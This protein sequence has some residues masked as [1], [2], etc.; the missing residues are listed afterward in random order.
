ML[1][2]EKSER[3]ILEMVS[4]E[5][6]V[7]QDHLLRKIDSAVDFTHIYDFVEDL[8]CADN[9]RPS[10]DPVVLFKM[11]LIQ[12]LYGITSLRRT[13]EEINMN[14]AYR[15]FLGYLLNEPIPHF[16]TISYNFRHRFTEDTIEKVFTWILYEAQKSGYLSPEVVFLDGTHIKANANINKK[17]KK[18]IPAAAR[19]YER[20]L[21][22]EI[23]EDR[24]AHGKKPFDG[25]SGSGAEKQ[26]EI[27]VSTT[28]PESGIF[29]KGEHKR[30]FAYEAHTVCDRHNFILDTVI[31]SGNVHDSVAFD[32]LYERVTERFPEIKIVTMDAGYKTPWICKRVIDDGRL[33]SLPYKRPMTKAGF[34]EWY[35]YVYDE[36]LDIVICPEYKSLQYSTTTRDGYREYKSLSYQCGN[37][38]TRNLCTESQSCQ[39]VVTRHIWADYIER[40][41]DIRHSPE[42]KGSYKLRSQ[43]IERVFADAKEKYGMRYTPYRGLKRVSMWVRLKFAAMNLKKL[44]MWRWKKGHFPLRKC[45]NNI[46]QKKN[47]YFAVA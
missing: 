42:G 3:N 28:D 14:I 26:K 46:I 33:P 34:H 8:Y 37:C 6:L 15:W 18:A 47:L 7:P 41:E 24:K 23:N 4:V 43:T 13:V 16:A 27:T 30:C 29:H 35:K 2:K 22:E 11:V 12:H 20:Q 10:V 36:Y 40:A 45:K 39:K 19:T 25:G 1:V 38:P 21:M 44:A 5:G 32:A 31:T 17:M 9:G